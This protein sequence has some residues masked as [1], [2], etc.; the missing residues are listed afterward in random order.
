MSSFHY[1]VQTQNSKHVSLE[2][3]NQRTGMI[4]GCYALYWKRGILVF[5]EEDINLLPFFFFFKQVEID[6]LKVENMADSD[7]GTHVSDI[8]E[9]NAEENEP[10][11]EGTLEIEHSLLSITP[12]LINYM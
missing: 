8:T 3:S 6:G 1:F 4:I 9:T 11:T 12:I 10:K 7:S 2:L 5:F